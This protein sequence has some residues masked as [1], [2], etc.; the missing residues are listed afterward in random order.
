MKSDKTGA[1]DAVYWAGYLRRSVDKN[2][3]PGGIFMIPAEDLEGIADA[4]ET[5]LLD[6]ANARDELNKCKA[7][8][9]DLSRWRD[10][11]VKALG[12]SKRAILKH[13]LEDHPDP[14]RLASLHGPTLDELER[15]GLVE[16]HFPPPGVN[17]AAG[18]TL[19]DDG[20]RA[21]ISVSTWEARTREKGEAGQ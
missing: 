17:Q 16:K 1:R 10:A 15:E 5:A 21:A 12:P 19:T 9:V 3:F 20:L 6:R 7:S 11:A 2:G 18:V 13:L 8:F 4:F 14:S